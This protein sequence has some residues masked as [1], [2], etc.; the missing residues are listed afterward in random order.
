MSEVLG[1]EPTPKLTADYIEQRLGYRVVVTFPPF[2]TNKGAIVEYH[3][4]LDHLEA[5]F[6]AENIFGSL[7]FEDG[8]LTLGVF[9]N[10]EVYTPWTEAN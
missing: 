6:G 8:Q 5:Q 7:F 2:E 1:Q 3:E 10:K 4:Q 9:V